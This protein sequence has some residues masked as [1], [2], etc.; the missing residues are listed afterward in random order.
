MPDAT[1]HLIFIGIKGGVLALDRATGVTRW[2]TSLKG[3]GFVNLV[4]DQNVLLATTRGEVFC[5][6]PATGQIL[7]NNGLSGFGYGIATIVA[8][9]SAQN[10]AAIAENELE[11]QQR[12]A[13]AT[14]ST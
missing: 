3:S 5:L 11:E 4:R 7:W 1:D 13:A 6:D 14:A 2:T 9:D 10:L 12:Q 8:G